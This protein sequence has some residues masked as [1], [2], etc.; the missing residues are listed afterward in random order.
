[1]TFVQPQSR[2]NHSFLPVQTLLIPDAVKSIDLKLDTFLQ[3]SQAGSE[4]WF[5]STDSRERR[6]PKIYHVLSDVVE[7]F[8]AN[9][10]R[11]EDARVTHFRMFLVGHGTTHPDRIGVKSVRRVEY[12]QGRTGSRSSWSATS[13]RTLPCAG[14]VGDVRVVGRQRGRIGKARWVRSIGKF[15]LGKKF[16]GSRKRAGWTRARSLSVG[17]DCTT[18]RQT[19]RTTCLVRLHGYAKGSCQMHTA[20]SHSQRLVYHSILGTSTS[21]FSIRHIRLYN[22]WYQRS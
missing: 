22:S 3:P 10:L 19:W 7:R 16:G 21:R 12:V 8:A 13:T 20:S 5:Y 11:N 6:L 17:S 14:G 4:D 15:A 18:C 2:T 1:M 9:Y